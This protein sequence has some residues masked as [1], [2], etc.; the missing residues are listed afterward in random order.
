L[1]GSEG[2]LEID[3][4]SEIKIL[5]WVIFFAMISHREQGDP[6]SDFQKSRLKNTPFAPFEK[7]GGGFGLPRG[8]KGDCR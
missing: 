8:K 1:P 6:K 2:E 4:K 3:R 5:Q 7:E